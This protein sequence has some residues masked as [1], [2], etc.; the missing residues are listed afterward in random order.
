MAVSWV[1]P[2]SPGL[3]AGVPLWGMMRHCESPHSTDYGRMAD[4]I[5]PD[6]AVHPTARSSG[7]NDQNGPCEDRSQAGPREDQPLA[8]CVLAA[9]PSQCF[10]APMAS[11]MS[12]VP[13]F[14]W[15]AAVADDDGIRRPSAATANAKASAAR[16]SAR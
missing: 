11:L 16:G 2:A 8:H 13:I 14:H 12:L 9:V 4:G 6:P 7:F 1:F 10:S 15:M 3:L 5:R